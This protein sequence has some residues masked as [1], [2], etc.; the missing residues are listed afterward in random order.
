MDPH[1]VYGHNRGNRC[2]T[3]EKRPLLHQLC[4]RHKLYIPDGYN[5]HLFPRIVRDLPLDVAQNRSFFKGLVV[6]ISDHR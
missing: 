4:I 1:P 5:F 2:E 6:C 3:F